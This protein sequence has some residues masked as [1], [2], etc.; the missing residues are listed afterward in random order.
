M[1]IL[2][3]IIHS[4]GIAREGPYHTLPYT[5]IH[6]TKDEYQPNKQQEEGYLGT[7]PN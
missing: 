4:Y 7:K 1:D 6:R 3:F 2:K 5:A